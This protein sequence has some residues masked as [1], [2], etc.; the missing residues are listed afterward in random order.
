VAANR[1]EQYRQL[2]RECL[3]LAKLVSVA[4]ACA[5]LV[6]MAE[7]WE[8]LAREQE[9]AT[10]LQH[11]ERSGRPGTSAASLSRIDHILGLEPP[12]HRRA[13]PVLERPTRIATSRQARRTSR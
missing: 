4:T 5:S 2:A 6:D 13:L 12:Q 10:D 1:V 9:R 8:R 3:K 7:E 11:A